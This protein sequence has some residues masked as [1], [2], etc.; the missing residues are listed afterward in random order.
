MHGYENQICTS[1]ECKQVMCTL[2]LETTALEN[3][4]R[5]KLANHLEG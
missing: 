5:S 1:A 2:Q 3:A 4:G